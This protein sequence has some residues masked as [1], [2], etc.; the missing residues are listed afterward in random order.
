VTLSMV[1]YGRTGRNEYGR[2]REGSKADLA[3]HLGT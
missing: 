1:D 2:P 3:V